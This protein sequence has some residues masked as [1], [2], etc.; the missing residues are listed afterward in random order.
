M[1]IYEELKRRG[2]MHQASNEEGVRKLLNT[3]NAYFYIGFDPTAESLHVG[4]LLQIITMKRLEKAGLKPIVLI[5][6][7]TGLIGDPGGKSQE[8]QLNSK[9]VVKKRS[10]LI[11]KQL[12]KFFESKKVI[13]VDNYD[14]IKNL[15]VLEFLRDIGK[16]FPL[17]AM[18]SKESIKMRLETGIS[19]T[20]FSY[21]VLQAYDFWSLFKKYNCRLQ[22]G[23]SDQWG[24]ITSGIDLIRRLK[25]KEVY[26]FTIPL[27]VTSDGQKMGKTEKGTVWL[28]SK[29]TSPYHFYQFWIN[30][31]DKD[32][33]RFLDYYT[34][35]SL[36][37]IKELEE[38][39]NKNPEKREAQRALA[40]EMTI[41]VHGKAAFKKSKTISEKLFYG[42]I[43]ELDKRDVEEIFFGAESKLLEFKKINLV[44]LLV[45][46]EVS[47]SKRQNREDIQ[48]GAIELNGNK[49]KDL[50]Y[51]IRK[52]DCLY[53]KYLIIK[54]GKKD[55]HFV[56]VR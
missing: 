36:E 44:D 34:F 29:M 25:T 20:E 26:G 56:Q 28:D 12:S 46:A 37:K 50:N 17:G 23:G 16:H 47:N 11:E 9:E 31:D 51:S 38:S 48:N 45:S 15:N 13:F 55:Y 5:G 40:E 33:V 53:G 30:A 41:F 1:D 3:K 21:M 4:N 42:S 18:L 49:I 54:R 35:L 24:N 8:R 52:K 14:W 19:F 32:A 39:L 2:L 6:G 27:V 10:D 43:L 22:I 7:A